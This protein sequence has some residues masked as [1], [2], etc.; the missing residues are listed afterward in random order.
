MPHEPRVF[1]I[2]AQHA[3]A[4][5]DEILTSASAILLRQ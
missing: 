1:D 5:S 3:H 4:L 2:Q